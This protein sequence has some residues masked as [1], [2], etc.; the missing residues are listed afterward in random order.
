MAPERFAVVFDSIIQEMPV[1]LDFDIVA[2][3]D[4]HVPTLQAPVD[5]R[6]YSDLLREIESLSTL[7]EFPTSGT[8][9][10]TLP[11]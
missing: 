4:S 10:T 7:P 3:Q 11:Q 1:H 9:D 5:S 2:H 6:R 8:G